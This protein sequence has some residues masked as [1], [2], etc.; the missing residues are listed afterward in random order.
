MTEERKGRIK[1]GGRSIE[2]A[3]TG[4]GP[5]SQFSNPASSSQ[6]LTRELTISVYSAC[7]CV[8]LVSYLFVSV[9]ICVSERD[10]EHR[11]K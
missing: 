3:M 4:A 7:L 10:I 5:C 9:Y 1:K 2:V 6:K 11:A 8:F